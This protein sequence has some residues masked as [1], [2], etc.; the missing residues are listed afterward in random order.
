MP[1]D[2]KPAPGAQGEGDTPN[3][4]D[5]LDARIAKMLDAKLNAALTARDKRTLGAVEKLLAERLDAALAKVAPEKPADKPADSGTSKADPEVLKL[6]EKLDALEKKNAEAEQRARAVE[7]RSRKDS[8]RATLREALEAKG[9]KGARARAVIADLEH[10]GALRFTDEGLPELAIK[11]SRMKG[12][13]AEELAF[14]DLAAGIEDWSKTN[15]AA[16]FL[17]P[18]STVTTN[19]AR[20]APVTPTPR[21]PATPATPATPDRSPSDAEVVQQ[22]ARQGIDIDALVR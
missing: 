20:R 19:A 5:E 15:D 9:I 14:D 12:A 1:D 10:S 21:G 17:P 2:K 8:A 18:P 6:R 7:E 3:Q 13:P 22:L 16:E 4:D 11:R